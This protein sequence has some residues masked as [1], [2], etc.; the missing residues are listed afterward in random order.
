MTFSSMQTLGST[1]PKKLDAKDIVSA[2]PASV[3]STGATVVDQT[4]GQIKSDIEAVLAGDQ[5]RTEKLMADLDKVD[6]DRMLASMSVIAGDLQ[7]LVDGIAKILGKKDLEKG[8]KDL[9]IKIRKRILQALKNLLAN[10][11]VP[12]SAPRSR[13]LV[14]EIDRGYEWMIAA[15]EGHAN[16]EGTS[17][18]DDLKKDKS[19][20]VLLLEAIPVNR[21]NSY[22]DRL[23]ACINHIKKGELIRAITLSRGV[24]FELDR[25]NRVLKQGKEK[26]DLEVGARLELSVKFKRFAKGSKYAPGMTPTQEVDSKIE[27]DVPIDR[28]G[29][30]YIYE[31]KSYPRKQFGETPEDLNQLLKYQTAIEQK[32][33][34]GATIEIRGRLSKEFLFWALG[35]SIVDDGG[36][37]DVEIIYNLQLP[38]GGEYRF[39]LKKAKH[40][41]GLKFE[42]ED[43]NYS[44]ED[45]QAINGLFKSIIDR[46]IIQYIADVNVDN[47]SEELAP[48]TKTENGPYQIERPDLFV[49][50]EN[51]RRE[52][53]QKRLT[54]KKYKSLINNE[55]L[56]SATHELA[57]PEMAEKWVTNI[58][59]AFQNEL[60]HGDPNNRRVATLKKKY[61]VKE[62]EKR[63]K[64]IAKV[65]EI[66]AKVREFE[67]NRAQ[68]SARDDLHKTKVEMGYHGLPEGVALD[69]EHII[70]DA[71]QMVDEK[72]KI[73][74]SYDKSETYRFLNADEL[75]EYLTPELDRTYQE[76]KIFDPLAVLDEER[77]VV[78]EFSS[79]NQ[80]E[81]A[82]SEKGIREK[83]IAIAGENF[84]RAESALKEMEKYLH[85][86]KSRQEKT[87]LLLARIKQDEGR[88]MRYRDKVVRIKSLIGKMDE[89]LT[90]VMEDKNKKIGRV[91][92]I[93]GAAGLKKKA[94]MGDVEAQSNLKRIERIVARINVLRADRAAKFKPQIE[95]L[96]K[97]IQSLYE[98]KIGEE[99]WQQIGVRILEENTQNMIKFIYVIRADGELVVSEEIIRG[100]VSGRA[101]HSELANGRNIYGA[102]E[103]AFAKQD[104]RWVLVE[105]NNGSGHYR[106]NFLT[107]N[108]V[109]AAIK[110]AGIDTAKAV[111]KEAILRAIGTPREMDML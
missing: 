39:V 29:K 60:E 79:S 9:L 34:D 72:K 67:L 22:V 59:E 20:F 49:E 84:R 11:A 2:V 75:N 73:K 64:I 17:L 52:T 90:G 57:A 8:R 14:A 7:V 102:G 83:K 42:N 103:L 44:E 99:D 43:K 77:L 88:L 50:Y 1:D 78:A 26:L 104:G 61:L 56:R 10:E 33:I 4:F 35:G 91:K 85:E 46:D 70:M 38:S 23:A 92:K 108:Y 55:N 24:L 62:P 45:T 48:Y 95:S 105:I 89:Q 58:F 80:A 106:P 97:E 28:D 16:A 25:I 19:S 32:K 13:D 30:P 65:V 82:S 66:V 37:P 54:E 21:R 41:N 15:I 107:L 81:R 94:K 110:K 86:L 63:Q 98:E 76:L 101:A 96:T 68:D 71:I 69:V 111:K 36:I 93:E 74:R 109:E 53:L 18:V 6:L 5:V 87:P 47:P 51:K 31:V 27:V 40:G 12:E 100:E 3:E